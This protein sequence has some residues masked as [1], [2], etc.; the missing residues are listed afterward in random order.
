MKSFIWLSAHFLAQQGELYSVK[1]LLALEFSFSWLCIF[2][3]SFFSRVTTLSLGVSLQPQ[4]ASHPSVSGNIKPSVAASAT[5]TRSLV[6][7]F[8]PPMDILG[9]RTCFADVFLLQAVHIFGLIFSKFVIGG[10]EQN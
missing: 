4:H 2:S 9:H 1:Y 10:M 5:K 3:F 6:R 8:E 7:S